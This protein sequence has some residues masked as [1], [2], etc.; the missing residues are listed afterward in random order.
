MSQS[1]IIRASQ[2]SGESF[3]QRFMTYVSFFR[4]R[5]ALCVCMCVKRR[6]RRRK[7]GELGGRERMNGDKGL[8]LL[9]FYECLCPWNI[10]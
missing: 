3:T 2:G 7:R 6:I 10:R 4:T 5:N 8:L 9:V 1:Y